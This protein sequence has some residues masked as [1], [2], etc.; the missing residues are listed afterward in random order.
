MKIISLT[1]LKYNKRMYS[2]TY[3]II[4]FFIIY[5]TVQITFKHANYIWNHALSCKE[6]DRIGILLRRFRTRRF[7]TNRIWQLRKEGSVYTIEEGSVYTCNLFDYQYRDSYNNCNS[8][9]P[10]SAFQTEKVSG[11]LIWF[12]LSMIVL[13]PVYQFCSSVWVVK[14]NSF[15]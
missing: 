9:L 12:S 10:K 7:R 4:L 14:N 6:C 3:F 2:L 8:A 1:L 5:D 15:F 13:L 11:D